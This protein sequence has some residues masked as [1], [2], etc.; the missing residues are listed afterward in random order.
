MLGTPGYPTNA[1]T[2]PPQLAMP[3]HPGAYRPPG[4]HEPHF[5]YVP[6]GTAG[7]PPEYQVAMPGML[8][9]PYGYPAHQQGYLPGFGAQPGAGGGV[10]LF[11]AGTAAPQL[12]GQLVQRAELDSFRQALLADMRVILQQPSSTLGLSPSAGA[13]RHTPA[14]SGGAVVTAGGGGPPPSGGDDSDEEDMPGLEPNEGP[15]RARVPPA[16]PARRSRHG[17]LTPVCAREAGC[18]RGGAP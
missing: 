13:E 8:P 11:G 17:A 3:G 12:L 2:E 14:A 18:Q 5:Q 9:A 15:P 1:P 10:P 6:L 16:W 4:V 7:Y